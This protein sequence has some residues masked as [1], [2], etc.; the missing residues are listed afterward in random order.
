M[1]TIDTL[2]SLLYDAGIMQGG[3]TTPNTKYVVEWQRNIAWRGWDIV[4]TGRAS[5]CAALCLLRDQE[6]E[7][8][9]SAALRRVR[10]AALLAEFGNDSEVH[11]VGPEKRC[12]ACRGCGYVAND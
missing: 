7:E 12:E 1:I 9:R 6:I 2:T 8:D 3:P 5:G 11:V 10:D 4:I